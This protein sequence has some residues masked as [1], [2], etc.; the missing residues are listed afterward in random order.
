MSCCPVLRVD[1]EQQPRARFGQAFPGIAGKLALLVGI[2]LVGETATTRLDSSLCAVII[3]RQTHR[4]PGQP[5]GKQAASR[6][7]QSDHAGEQFLL[8]MIEDFAGVNAA[9]PLKLCS[10]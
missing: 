7:R 1:L 4:S 3:M 9:L 5:A 10:R 2:Q 8:V 6:A